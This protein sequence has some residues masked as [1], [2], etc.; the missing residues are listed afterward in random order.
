MLVLT[1]KCGEQVVIG[2]DIKVKVLEIRGGRVKLG[3]VGPAEVP[4]HREEIQ[5][6]VDECPP[7]LSFA[8]CA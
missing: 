5:Q 7:A 2:R 4:M 1:R 8:E 3:L 6:R